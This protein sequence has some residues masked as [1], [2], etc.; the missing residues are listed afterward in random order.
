[1]NESLERLQAKKILRAKYLNALYDA[2][3]GNSRSRVGCD[4]IATK[5]GMTR[6]E[7]DP[8]LQYLKEERLLEFVDVS[9]RIAI[10]HQGVLEIEQAREKPSQPTVH[11]PALNIFVGNVTNSQVT[12]GS[13]HSVQTGTFTFT[14][15]SDVAEF[16]SQLKS[17]TPELGLNAD[18]LQELRADLDALQSQVQSNRPKFGIVKECLSSL[19][20]ILE[21]ATAKIVAEPLL[22]AAIAL[23][24]STGFAN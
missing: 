11:F 19:R 15:K 9:G 12:Q 22:A 20:R 17:A 14:N 1:V 2:V 8:V 18:M 7:M 3:D 4:E 6:Q 10:T 16:I 21:G 24:H 23:M 13:P 5:L